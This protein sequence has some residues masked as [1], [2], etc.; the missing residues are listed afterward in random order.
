M[1]LEDRIDESADDMTAAETAPR[2]MNETHYTAWKRINQNYVIG[3]I[4]L[5][6][7][8]GVSGTAEQEVISFFHGLQL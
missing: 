1:E 6:C 7:L 3:S 8:R 4:V 5:S 2:P